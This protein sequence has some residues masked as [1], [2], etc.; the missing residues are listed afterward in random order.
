MMGFMGILIPGPCPDAMVSKVDPSGKQIWGT[1]L[2]GPTA[3]NGT[4]LAIDTNGNVAFTGS[5]GGQF[6]TTPGAAIQSSTTATAL[7]PRSV[8]MAASFFTPL[9][10]RIP[11]L[12][13]RPSR[14]IQR[15]ARMSPVRH[16]RAMLSY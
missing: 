9:T 3:D 1:R 8:R 12:L 7:P 4:A 2:G 15:A 6:P 13:L 5:T 11:W 16:P 14:L 10:C